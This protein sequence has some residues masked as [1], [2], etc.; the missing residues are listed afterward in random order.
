MSSKYSANVQHRDR[1]VID[2]PVV[3]STLAVSDK[4]TVPE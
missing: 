2:Y 3:T 4:N 1:T